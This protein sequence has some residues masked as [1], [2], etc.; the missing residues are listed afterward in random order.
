ME[1]FSNYISVVPADEKTFL[2]I[3]S[4]KATKPD[5]LHKILGSQQ[6]RLENVVAFG[7][8][9]PDLDMLQICGIPIAVANAIPEVKAATRYRTASND[10]DGVAIALEK[11]L[12]I[13]YGR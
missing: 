13:L 6:E 5:A 12:E 11:M 2:N 4:I 8:D 3:T 1:N 10:D 7:D 9:Y